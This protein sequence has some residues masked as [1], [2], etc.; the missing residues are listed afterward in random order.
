MNRF[1]KLWKWLIAFDAIWG[2][3]CLQSTDM[4]EYGKESKPLPVSVKTNVLCFLAHL[5]GWILVVVKL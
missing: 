3:K 4:Y 2:L 1:Y 5:H